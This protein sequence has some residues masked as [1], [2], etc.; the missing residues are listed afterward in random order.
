MKNRIL[1]EWTLSRWLILIIG[2]IVLIESALRT[3]WVGL[4]FGGYFA[5]M[6]L[7]GFGCAGGACAGG[8]CNYPTTKEKE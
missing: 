2:G 7:F 6:G 3:E 4:I 5:A 1:T 8:S